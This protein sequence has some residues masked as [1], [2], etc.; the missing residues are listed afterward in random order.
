MWNSVTIKNGDFYYVV[1]MHEFTRYWMPVLEEELLF[2]EL[3]KI[4]DTIPMVS[5]MAALKRGKGTKRLV[6]AYEQK[7]RGNHGTGE[8]PNG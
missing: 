8:Y 2:L 4:P 6:K 3:D 7:G 5:R 1:P